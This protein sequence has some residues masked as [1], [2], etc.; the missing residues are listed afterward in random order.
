MG[1]KACVGTSIHIR[2]SP[3]AGTQGIHRIPAAVSCC[4]LTSHFPAVWCLQPPGPDALFAWEGQRQS[5]Y[6]H[7]L[8]LI[9]G[10]IRIQVVSYEQ[11]LYFFLSLCFPFPSSLLFLGSF[12][13]F[14]VSDKFILPVWEHTETK[15]ARLQSR[16]LVTALKSIIL[17][18]YFQVDASAS[19]FSPIVLYVHV[20]AYVAWNTRQPVSE[21]DTATHGAG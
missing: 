7:F 6:L 4:S 12:F 9:Q 5:K 11:N 20:V 19:D 18:S 3:C 13:W 16:V 10:F 1:L 14:S 2:A 15:F 21:H 8:H 17:T